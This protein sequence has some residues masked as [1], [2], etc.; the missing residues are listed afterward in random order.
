MRRNPLDWLVLVVSTIAIAL[1][2]G[3]LAVAAVTGTRTE[4][5]VVVE[6][7][8]PA[9]ATEGWLVQA[10]VRNDGDAAALTVVVE[11]S[12]MV[13]TTE[14][15]SELTLDLVP[16]GSTVDIAFGFSGQPADL[17]ARVVGYELP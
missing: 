13:G 15:T 8:V 5:D 4:A 3:Y 7:G 9:A 14:E 2:V 17:Q 1:L 10:T 11:A 16:Q 6:L 12:A